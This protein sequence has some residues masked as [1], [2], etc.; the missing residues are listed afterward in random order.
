MDATHTIATA[1]VTIT[2]SPSLQASPSTVAGG[3]TVIITQAITL[4]PT[5]A[6]TAA[7]SVT[8]SADTSG[9]TGL[10]PG[11]KLGIGVGVPL[12]ILFILGLAFVAVWSSWRH[13]RDA[14]RDAGLPGLSNPGNSGYATDNIAMASY[15]VPED[16]GDQGAKLV[17]PT[18]YVP[19]RQY[20]P[21]SE[22]PTVQE[23]NAGVHEL[24]PG[25]Y[26]PQELDADNAGVDQ[27][28]RGYR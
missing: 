7:A 14:K 1:T 10:S 23:R 11:A 12:G 28:N 21:M 15:A 2:P 17:K 19:V 6:S 18:G 9:S 8:N 4:S 25:S 26:Q 5:T 13:S 24:P 20:P 3:S 27:K 22:L 16:S